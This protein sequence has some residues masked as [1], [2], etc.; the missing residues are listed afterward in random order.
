[1]RKAT[2]IIALLYSLITVYKLLRHKNIR[3][4]KKLPKLRTDLV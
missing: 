4:N 1:M 2:T 3:S